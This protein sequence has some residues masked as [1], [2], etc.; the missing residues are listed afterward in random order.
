MPTSS[1]PCRTRWIAPGLLLALTI[2]P[3]LAGMARLVWLAS[4][5]LRP[6]SARFAAGPA[7]LV[8][9][10]LSASAFC[11]VG[12]FQFTPSIRSRWPGWHRAAGR[13]LV[14]AGLAA[15]ISGLWMVLFY[16]PGV[17]DGALL[18]GIRLVSGSAMAASI[19]LGI[20]AIYRQDFVSH[21]A[22]MMRGYAIGMGAGAQVVVFLAWALLGGAANEGSR[23]LLMGAGWA[24][25]LIVAEGVIRHRQAAAMIWSQDTDVFGS[26]RAST[27][28]LTANRLLQRSDRRPL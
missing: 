2:V 17:N 25:N 11:V 8:L 21:T 28:A 19:L 6:D 1:T 12:A 22:W 10:I 16:P 4:G 14:P 26:R 13:L 9:H 7:P 3:V 18:M 5:T 23:A 15:A 20:D 27:N 24:I